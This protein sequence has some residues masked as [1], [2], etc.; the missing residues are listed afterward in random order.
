MFAMQAKIPVVDYNYYL[1]IN[2]WDFRIKDITY[3]S[4]LVSRYSR[5]II[6][7]MPASSDSIQ[8]CFTTFLLIPITTCLIKVTLLCQICTAFK[9]IQALQRL[10]YGGIIVTSLYYVSNLMVAIVSCHP[11]NGTDRIAIL[12]GLASK[13]CVNANDIH[14]EITIATGVFNIISDF[15][16]LIIP[17]RAISKLSITR[18]Q[19]IG[20]YLMFSAG[21]L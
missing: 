6:V 15:Y 16:I 18:K 7:Y 11:R 17:L 20:V 4:L 10:C 9:P 21:G 3:T 12:S 5:L 14:Q 8:I 19:K 13:K 2:M 1:G